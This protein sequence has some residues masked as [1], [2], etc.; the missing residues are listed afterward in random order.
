MG[1]VH[2]LP[3]GLSFFS[4]AF[5]EPVLLEAAFA[6]EQATLHAQPPRGFGEWHPAVSA[7]SRNRQ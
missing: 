3:V 7:Q 5:S 2:G 1:Q 6:F 4:T